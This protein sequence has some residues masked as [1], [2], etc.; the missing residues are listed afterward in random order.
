MRDKKGK[1]GMRGRQKHSLIKQAEMADGTVC[2][3]N[4]QVENVS[5]RAG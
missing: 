2:R 3:K 1:I 4:K 5:W